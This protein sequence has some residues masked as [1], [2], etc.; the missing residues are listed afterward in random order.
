MLIA[1]EPAVG[2]AYTPAAL[3]VVWGA[4]STRVLYFVGIKFNIK[5][6]S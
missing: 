6:A 5:K 1:E 2:A 4:R 3:A